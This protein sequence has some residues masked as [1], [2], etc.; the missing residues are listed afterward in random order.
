VLFIECGRHAPT[1][2]QYGGATVARPA[3]FLLNSNSGMRGAHFILAFD[4]HFRQRLSRFTVRTE[5]SP[6]LMA[7]FAQTFFPSLLTLDD[8]PVFAAQ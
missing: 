3:K 6:F 7:F 5:V 2:V 8:T 1:E 4:T